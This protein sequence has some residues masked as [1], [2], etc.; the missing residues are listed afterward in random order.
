VKSREYI[1]SVR[2]LGALTVSMIA[3]WSA[4]CSLFGSQNAPAPAI[5]SHP[6]VQSA[7]VM[8]LPPLKIIRSP[9]PPAPILSNKPSQPQPSLPQPP[10][11][12]P[13]VTLGDSGD[14]RANAQHLLDQAT[15]RMTLINRAELA[16]STVSTYQEANELINEAQRAMAEK[17]YLAASS[18]AEKASA[19]A[20]QLSPQK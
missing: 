16:D 5:Q 8:L 13:L 18:L 2:I 11:P 15:A 17:D 3:A 19:L 20:S 9:S 1:T 6:P 12:A 14:A 4:G 7:P 10:S